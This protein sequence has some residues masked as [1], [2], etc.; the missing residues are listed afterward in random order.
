M[1]KDG[2]ENSKCGFGKFNSELWYLKRNFKSEMIF[3]IKYHFANILSQRFEVYAVKNGGYKKFREKMYKT[4]K[5]P[6][7]LNT[8]RSIISKTPFPLPLSNSIS[9]I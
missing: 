5:I 4:N 2:S 6:G 9:I 8:H 7:K 1:D 3:R